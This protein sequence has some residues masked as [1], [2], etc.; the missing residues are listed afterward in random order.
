[1]Y[2]CCFDNGMLSPE[3]SNQLTFDVLYGFIRRATV[4][5]LVG[6][7]FQFVICMDR[8][9]VGFCCFYEFSA[10][11]MCGERFFPLGINILDM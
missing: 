2:C 10:R 8:P 1:M 11:F 3:T 9:R 4:Y 6:L 5:V 7:S